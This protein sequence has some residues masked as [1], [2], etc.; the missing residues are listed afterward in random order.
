MRKNAFFTL[1]TLLFFFA[2]APLFG[3]CD[4]EVQID[5]D[6]SGLENWVDEGNYEDPAG[7][8]WD[9]ANRTV[10]LLPL[11]LD[12]NVTKSSDAHTGNFS[13]KLTT[14]IWFTQIASATLFTGRFTPNT[15][16]PE[17]S[18]DFG[19]AFTERP[20]NFRFWYKYQPFNG[21]SAEVYTYVTKWNGTSRDTV[22]RAY[23]KIYDPVFE[24]TEMDIPFVYASEE[25]PDSVS[26][27]FASSAGGN[28][29]QGQ[30]GNTLYV[31]DVELYNCA[32]GISTAFM[33][34]NRISAFPNPVENGEINFSLETPVNEGILRV[35]G[36]DGKEVSSYSFN[37][38]RCSINVHDWPRGM[39]R[40]M[41]LDGQSSAA[42]GS[43]SFV[44]SDK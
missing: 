18:V 36:N 6:N 10:D 2:Q 3:Q 5:I 26:I 8:F 25:M 1:I 38:D 30:E 34:E 4:V 20:D 39:Y 29:F 42:L 11:F 43:G 17:A 22:G 37:G 24:W 41:V 21:D 12:P 16:N 15:S 7:D 31:D 13:A 23:T 27:V 9:T 14:T 35:F 28:V 19:Q 32:T 33:S 40:F 44:I